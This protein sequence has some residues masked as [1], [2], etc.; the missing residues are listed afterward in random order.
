MK[1]IHLTIICSLLVLCGCSSQG[2][3]S[4]PGAMARLYARLQTH[5]TTGKA[6]LKRGLQAKEAAKTYR[7]RIDLSLHPGSAMVTEVEVSCPDRERIVTHIQD[8]TFETVR[9]GNDGYIQQE[10]GQWTKQELPPDSYPCGDKPGQPSPW[11]MMNE[12]R[13]MST[14]LAKMAGNPA[15]PITIEPGAL[16]TVNSNTCQQ[17]I[18]SFQHP[19]AKDKAPHGMSYTVCLGNT[20]RLPVQLVMGTGGLVVTYSDWNKPLQIEVPTEAKLDTAAAKAH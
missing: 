2:N 18:V 19:G 11:A 20:D 3:G 7:M 14:V 16:T 1:L 13:D 10:N 17:W 6:E 15:S 9:I 4:Q 12:G 5:L 8:K